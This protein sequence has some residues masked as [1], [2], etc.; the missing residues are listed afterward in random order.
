MAN[1]LAK[2]ASAAC[3]SVGLGAIAQ[4]VSLTS[5]GNA[6]RQAEIGG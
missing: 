2:L 3:A 1:A 5:D 4:G 6:H